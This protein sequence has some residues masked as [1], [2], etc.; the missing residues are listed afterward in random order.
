MGEQSPEAIAD[1]ERALDREL[2]QVVRDI[3]SGSHCRALKGAS[4]RRRRDPA[5]QT[6][7]GSLIELDSHQH[8]FI[9]Q[10]Q[11]FRGNS[12]AVA[13]SAL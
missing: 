11:T 10:A 6:A 2:R 4:V 7:L 12:R 13:Y 5:A 9:I 1:F 3:T 8:D